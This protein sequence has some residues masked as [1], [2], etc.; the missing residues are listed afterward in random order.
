M[1]NDTNW[2]L[3]YRCV[4][5]LVFD[6]P[7]QTAFNTSTSAGSFEF[8][9]AQNIGE[10]TNAD[11]PQQAVI[12]QHNNG[13]GEF[14]ILVKSAT[15]AS[16]ADWATKTISGTVPTGT[17]ATSTSFNA[18]PVPTT[19]Y[20]YVVVGGG[21]GGVPVADKLAQAGHSVLLI[22]K[23]VASSAR[24]GGSMRYVHLVEAMLTCLAIRP[25]SGWLDGHNLTW[26]DIPGECNR[27]WSGGTAGVACDDTD[28]M[29][30][31]V[32]GGGT[33]V[34]AGLWWNVRGFRAA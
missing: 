3:I 23:G 30:G 27:I 33:A 18:T 22:E 9:W 25:E 28:Q 21:A 20:D 5:C 26:F 11:N 16:Y 4:N 2:M 31:C 17:S 10:P 12:D 19:K 24:W 8:G 34:N 32:L 29:A 14:Q 6:D 13:M 15:Q 1:I 7:S